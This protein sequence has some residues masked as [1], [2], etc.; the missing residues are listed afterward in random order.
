MQK[1]GEVNVCE[2]VKSIIDPDGSV[3]LDVRRGHYYSLN[4]VGAFI[5]KH[6]ELGLTTAEIE[7]RIAAN[8]NAA[9]AARVHEDV[10]HFI[11]QLIEKQ[12]VV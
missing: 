3:L 2:G 9:D 6:L 1:E 12:L 8:Y 4:G 5:W 7:G 11:S 10:S